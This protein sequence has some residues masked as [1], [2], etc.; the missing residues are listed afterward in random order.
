MAMGVKKKRGVRRPLPRAVVSRGLDCII[1]LCCAGLDFFSVLQMAGWRYREL[2]GEDV[3][4]LGAVAVAAARGL[5]L[6]VV[7]VRGGQQVPEDQL[8]NLPRRALFVREPLAGD[9]TPC[10]VTPVI[11]HG[12]ASPETL[13]DLTWCR[14]RHQD[15]TT[16]RLW[17]ARITS[18]KMK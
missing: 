15:L 12:I 18:P 11:L 6:R 4:E 7:V 9:T 8:R 10:K 5:L 17:Q 14:V 1:V 16:N 13:L 2:D 3:G